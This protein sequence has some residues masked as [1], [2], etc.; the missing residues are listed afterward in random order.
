MPVALPATDYDGDYILEFLD[1]Q[2]V[3]YYGSRDRDMWKGSFSV[4]D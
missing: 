1:E 2:T 4:E 3:E